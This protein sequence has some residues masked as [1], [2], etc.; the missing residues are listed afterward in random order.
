MNI[1]AINNSLLSF[2]P[3]EQSTGAEVD[4]PTQQHFASLLNAPEATASPDSLVGAQGAL[5]ELAVGTEMTAKVAGS[6]TQA[7]NKLV[8]IS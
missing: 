6:L 4:I 8:N 3:V 7:V 2:L 1:D 5:S